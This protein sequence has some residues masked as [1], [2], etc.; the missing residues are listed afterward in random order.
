MYRHGHWRGQPGTVPV[1]GHGADRPADRRGY[2]PDTEGELS[3]TV[4]GPAD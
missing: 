4:L 2:R 1:R 3:G